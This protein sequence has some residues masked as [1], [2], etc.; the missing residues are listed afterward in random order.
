M[1]RYFLFSLEISYVLDPL[2]TEY[3]FSNAISFRS[4]CLASVFM[5]ELYAYIAQEKCISIAT[6]ALS[7]R[8]TV[9][10]MDGNIVRTDYSCDGNYALFYFFFFAY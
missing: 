10:C 6:A 3:L 5:L 1:M 7:I 2:I 4:S 8:H 9:L